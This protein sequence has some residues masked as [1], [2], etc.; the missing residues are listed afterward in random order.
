MRTMMALARGFPGII[1]LRGRK[2]ALLSLLL[3][4]YSMHL[5]ATASSSTMMACILP[6]AATLRAVS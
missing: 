6:P 3:L 1:L 2:V 5:A 4:R